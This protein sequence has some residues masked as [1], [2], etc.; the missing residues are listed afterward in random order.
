[1]LMFQLEGLPLQQT[2]LASLPGKSPSNMTRCF[3]Q[4]RLELIQATTV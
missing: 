4:Q 3:M 2:N 1:M